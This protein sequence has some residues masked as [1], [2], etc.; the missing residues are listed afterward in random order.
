MGEGKTCRVAEFTADAQDPEELEIKGGSLNA[1]EKGEIKKKAFVLLEQF[2]AEL[3][4]T[5]GLPLLVEANNAANGPNCADGVAT[6]TSIATTAPQATTTV[7]QTTSSPQSTNASQTAASS[8]AAALNDS[9]SFNCPSTE[10]YRFLTETPRIIAWSRSPP[11]GLPQL[12]LPGASFSLFGG[13][14]V[15]KFVELKAPSALLLEW[16]LKDWTAPSKVNLSIFP[17][18]E[19]SCRLE[20]QQ[21]GVPAGEVERIKD[22]WHAYY[23]TPIKRLIGQL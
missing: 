13:N 23:W 11:S 9:I 18:T 10:L 19:G 20:L 22:N 21:E 6:K 1:Q 8:Q 17:E 5:H 16:K 14:I 3:H 4:T 7:P 15:G 2:K 12:I